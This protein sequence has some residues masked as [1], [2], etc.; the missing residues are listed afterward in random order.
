MFQKKNSS[1]TGMPT[2]ILLDIQGMLPRE[3]CLKM[4]C[5]WINEKNVG[6]KILVWP[7]HSSIDCLISN[8]YFYRKY[9]I[10]RCVC[11]LTWECIIFYCFML[12]ITKHIKSFFISLMK[13]CEEYVLMRPTSQHPPA[14]NSKDNS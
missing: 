14:T 12:C 7:C 2:T 5:N 10:Q 11:Y 13:L 3:I 4:H 8:R 9:Y 1:F 6:G